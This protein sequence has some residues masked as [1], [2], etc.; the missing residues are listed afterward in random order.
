MFSWCNSSKTT[1]YGS[2]LTGPTT[3]Y[4]SSES[5][6]VS[7][8]QR[9]LPGACSMADRSI[10]YLHPSRSMIDL[11]YRAG[12][13][14]TVNDICSHQKSRN[15]DGSSVGRTRMQVLSKWVPRLS[16]VS[17][18]MHVYCLCYVDTLSCPVFRSQH[19]HMWLTCATHTAWS[20]VERDAS[21]VSRHL[22]RE[23][24]SWLCW[25]LWPAS[26]STPFPCM[27]TAAIG[28]P[29]MPCHLSSSRTVL[30]STFVAPIRNS[31]CP[32]LHILFF[33]TKS[34]Y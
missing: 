26:S 5:K 1:W 8:V 32:L 12:F 28:R 22:M 2:R 10:A 19:R 27:S 25:Y 14:C 4:R 11:S 21:L 33:S 3:D 29:R 20:S 17:H 18:A 15:I 34:I 7:T 23:S 6:R 9:V 24:M 13:P 16:R 30:Q 31:Q